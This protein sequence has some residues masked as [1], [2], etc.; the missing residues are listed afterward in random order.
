[1]RAHSGRIQYSIVN[2]QDEEVTDNDKVSAG[3][4]ATRTLLANLR[5]DPTVPGSNDAENSDNDDDDDSSMP[6]PSEGAATPT[7]TNRTLKTQTMATMVPR[8]A[9]VATIAS[10]AYLKNRSP[11]TKIT[12]ARWQF[13][14]P[15][16]P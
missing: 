13:S 15:S 12:A 1:M 7:R 4:L 9:I 10:T 11:L 6:G 14:Q 3:N 16:H 2:R 8:V 5:Q